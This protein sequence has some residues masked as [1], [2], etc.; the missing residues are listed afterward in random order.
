MFDKIIAVGSLSSVITMIIR[1][2]Y[3]Q[4]FDDKV[5]VISILWSLGVGLVVSVLCKISIRKKERQTKFL[6]SE[7][8]SDETIILEGPAKKCQ[9]NNKVWG[10]LIL[11]SERLI[12]KTIMPSQK[13]LFLT[14]IKN[15][16]V[17]KIL[18]ILQ[19]GLI[20]NM[21]DS[22][23]KFVVDY[24]QDWKDIIDCQMKSNKS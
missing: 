22:T 7:I 5:I 14:N 13:N 1:L 23:Q 18:G 9:P 16:K 17:K 11:T 19:D 24:P 21:D 4:S 8:A 2:I 20:I 12:F 15:I 6:L 3:K 10:K